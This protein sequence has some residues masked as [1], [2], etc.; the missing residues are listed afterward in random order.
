M[1][2]SRRVL[3]LLGM[4]RSEVLFLSACM[5]RSIL[6]GLSFILA[7]SWHT[8]LLATVAVLLVLYGLRNLLKAV[9]AQE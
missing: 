8:V 4:A 6:T 2:R 1:A 7:R 3:L 9:T 5:A